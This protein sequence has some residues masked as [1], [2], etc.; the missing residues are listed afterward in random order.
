MKLLLVESP[1]KCKKIESFLDSSYKV[2]ATYGHL[3]YFDSLN[4]ISNEYE[5]SFKNMQQKKSQI[6]K[7]QKLIN[8]SEEVILATDNDR[9][10]EAI[11]WHVIQM[12]SLPI[13][14]KRI[15]FNEITRD[16]ILNALQN[17]SLIH[18]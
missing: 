4:D 9:E 10:G 2:E 16:A 15:L 14:S 7:L 11:A 12:F 17:L 3:R 8:I 5:I 1:A 13:N 6:S 18:I